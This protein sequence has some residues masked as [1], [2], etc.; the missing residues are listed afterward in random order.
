M[1]RVRAELAEVGCSVL[2]G[3]LRPEAVAELAREGEA[4]APHAHHRTIHT[5]P[6]SSPD[7]ER[8]PP[9]HP[10]RIFME[11]NNAFV[12]A[13][14][15]PTDSHL[16][17]LYQADAFRRFVADCLGEGEIYEYADPLAK[18]VLNVL[19]PGA[20]HPWHY[21]T[22]E[23][24][25][26]TLLQPAEAGGAFQYC[27]GIRS[28][29]SENDDQVSAVLRGLDEEPIR[30]LDLKSGDLQLFY[31]RYSL[32]RVTRVEGERHR[33]TGI[34]AY[35]KRPGAIGRVE[36]TQRLFG[37]VT[38]AHREAEASRVRADQLRD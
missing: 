24:I 19:R 1:A 12:A 33:I 22:N 14:R 32:H 35:A 27:P 23:F 30:R 13:D 3:F 28:P 5:N 18:L 29:E 20:Q 16:M 26:S 15:I 11:R 37:R 31:G 17:R 8:L 10:V 34:F 25:V 21:D 6:Y 4:L 9:E 38:E 2:S 7:D 36:R